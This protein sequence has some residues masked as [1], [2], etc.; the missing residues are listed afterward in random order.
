MNG[1]VPTG[2][3]L[4]NLAGLLSAAQMCLGTI[5][6]WAI[7]VAN[8]TFG[9]LNVTVTCLPAAETLLICDQMPLAS[10]AG[11]F[12]SRSKV[13]T[14]SAAENGLPSLHLTPERIV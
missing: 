13:K 9:A 8:G 10:S 3:V 7:V 1:P 2:W 14:T 4:V 6:V 12:F 11:Y 5:G